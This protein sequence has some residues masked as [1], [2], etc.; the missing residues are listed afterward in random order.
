V[1]RRD[2]LDERIER[3]G[4]RATTVVRGEASK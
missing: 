2:I 3:V 4:L 1:R